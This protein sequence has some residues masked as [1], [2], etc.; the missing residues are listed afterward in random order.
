MFEE[1]D[2][3]DAGD[4]AANTASAASTDLNVTLVNEVASDPST[5]ADV[6]GEGFDPNAAQ[7]FI[8]SAWDGF[9]TSGGM[10]STTDA[11]NKLFGKNFENYGANSTYSALSESA[12]NGITGAAPIG[13]ID[14]ALETTSSAGKA[15]SDWWGAAKPETRNALAGMGLGGMMAYQKDRAQRSADRAQKE[16]L[17]EKWARDD[18][19][20]A[21]PDMRGQLRTAQSFGMDYKGGN[22]Q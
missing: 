6:Y 11:L 21:V 15:V 12:T 13:L 22:K 18:R 17:N 9:L 19:N 16:M 20:S 2:F 10:T 5:W 7:G 14:T 1:Y 4:E 3:S 8:S